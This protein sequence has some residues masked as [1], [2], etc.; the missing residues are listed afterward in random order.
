MDMIP[1]FNQSGVLP[2]YLPGSDPGAGPAFIS[3]YET[4]MVEL[5]TRFG[6]TPERQ[7]L[8]RG[9]LKMRKQLLAVGVVSGFQWLDGSFSEEIE[10][11]EGRSPKD[12]DV[13]TY[14]EIPTEINRSILI[15]SCSYLFDP[16]EAKKSFGC[17]AF[18][19]DMNL[20]SEMIHAHTCYWLS[21]FSHKRETNLWKGMLRV[22]LL[23]N[24]EE[25]I[26]AL[27]GSI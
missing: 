12:I 24:D 15:S 17:H 10:I 3:P 23:S 22:D 5:V 2:P 16:E 19:V 21:L 14:A 13:V 9:L 25:A 18:F 11:T 7:D 27:G 26:A 8:I 20:S 1:N 4:D 6:T